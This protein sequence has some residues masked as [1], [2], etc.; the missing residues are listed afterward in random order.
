MKL[1]LVSKGKIGAILKGL[2]KGASTVMSKRATP[3]MSYLGLSHAIWSG[4]FHQGREHAGPFSRKGAPLILLQQ[5]AR[6]KS[7][8]VG[9]LGFI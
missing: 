4:I 7:H 9:L 1:S 8:D 3:G 2:Y 6:E 5:S